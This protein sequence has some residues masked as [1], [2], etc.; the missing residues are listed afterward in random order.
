M[1]GSV[2]TKHVSICSA[3]YVTVR[4]ITAVPVLSWY[5]FHDSESVLAPYAVKK[6]RKICVDC[7][8]FYVT[9]IYVMVMLK[10]TC[11]L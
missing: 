8:C 1:W 7:D 6:A 3:V 4:V 11:F 2:H 10:N 9:H 5:L